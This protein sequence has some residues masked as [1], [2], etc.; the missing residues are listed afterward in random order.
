ELYTEVVD[1]K[2]EMLVHFRCRT[3]GTEG[4]DETVTQTFEGNLRLRSADDFQSWTEIGGA[5]RAPEL[6]FS[7]GVKVTAGDDKYP[8]APDPGSPAPPEHK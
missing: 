1:P 7:K 6:A 5:I 4:P 8:P 3:E 2:E